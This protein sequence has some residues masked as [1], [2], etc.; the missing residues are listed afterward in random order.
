MIAPTH[1]RIAIAAE[2]VYAVAV[3]R[4]P[5]YAR[6]AFWRNNYWL[7]WATWAC[8]RCDLRNRADTF[9]CAKCGGVE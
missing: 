2:A 6:Q 9:R 4:E 5:E 3:G 8:R 7:T 1:L